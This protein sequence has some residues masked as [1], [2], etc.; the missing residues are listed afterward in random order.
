MPK[1]FARVLA[2]LVLSGLSAVACGGADAP[3]P[4]PEPRPAPEKAEIRVG[5]VPLADAAPFFIALRKGYFA[6]EGLTVRAVGATGSGMAVPTLE[7]GG[8]DVAQTDYVTTFMAD[9]AG[10]SLQ[11]AG[12]MAEAAEDSYGLVVPADSP[13]TSVRKLKGRTVAVNNLN[14]L[15]TLTV[16]RMLKD[17]GLD[18]HDVRFAEVP[19]PEMSGRLKSGDVDAAWAG[20]PFLSGPEGLR[21]LTDPVPGRLRG[22]PTSGWMVTEKW[23]AENP[24]TLAAFQRALAKAQRVAADRKEV[25]AVLP[26]YTKLSPQAVARV[27]VGTFPTA[28]DPG[29]LQQVAD[30]LEKHGYLKGPLDVTSLLAT[31][32]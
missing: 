4:S 15:A 13:I 5:F 26:T 2:V 6:E 16:Q 11:L 31:T 22:W 1:R 23:R 10:K 28:A 14:G 27:S 7:T 19:F 21:R 9:A 20:E 32:G 3:P 8:L 30:V 17:A 24:R 18:A 25:E 12:V 29:R